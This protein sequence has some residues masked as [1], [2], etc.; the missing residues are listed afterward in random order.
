MILEG[1]Q[2]SIPLALLSLRLNVLIVS[3][4][5][6]LDAVGLILVML[7]FPI[8]ELWSHIEVILG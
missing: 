2:D 5:Y 1:F 8:E 4:R 6:I 7:P 3:A